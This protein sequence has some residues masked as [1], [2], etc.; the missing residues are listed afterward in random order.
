MTYVLLYGRIIL[1][2]VYI[3]HAFII[4]S[5]MDGHL[6]WADSIAWLLWIVLQ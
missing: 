2:S 1:H 3:H 6:H 4:H 5:P